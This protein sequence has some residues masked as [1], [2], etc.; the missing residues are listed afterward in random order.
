LVLVGL[1]LALLSANATRADAGACAQNG[2]VILRMLAQRGA[3]ILGKQVVDDD[4]T[5]NG[6]QAGVGRWQIGDEN[7]GAEPT[8]IAPGL[9]VYVPPAGATSA[10]LQVGSHSYELEVNGAKPLAAP[11]V[12]K[13]SASTSKAFTRYPIQGPLVA[14]VKRIPDDAVALVVFGIEDGKPVARSFGAV[15]DA[16]GNTLTLYEP[17]GRCRQAGPGTQT[18]A[19]DKVKLAWLDRNG[20]L[21]KLSATLRVAK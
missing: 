19:G 12:Q 3:L 13:L 14:K 15:K 17:G 6:E 7:S 1:V 16:N 21:G 8:E 9:L 2:R 5:D 18:V 11:S 4:S 10:K 20:T